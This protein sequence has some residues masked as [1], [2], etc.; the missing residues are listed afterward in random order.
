[1]GYDVHI[2]WATNW[3]DSESVPIRL[4]EWLEYVASDPEF[5]LDNFAEAITPQGDTLRYDNTGL[6]VWT[7]Y[8]D[9]DEQGSVWF[10]YRNGRIVVKNANIEI[11]AKMKE[12]ADDLG[13]RVVGDEGEEY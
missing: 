11:R 8:S 2:T 9:P 12:I 5:R 4:T 10:D 13:A 7:A 6:A 1:M 3:S